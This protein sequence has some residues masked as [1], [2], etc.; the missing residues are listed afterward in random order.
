ML[1]L[2]SKGVVGIKKFVVINATY[3]AEIDETILNNHGDDSIWEHFDDD[4]PLCIVPSTTLEAEHESI[5]FD[6]IS[7]TDGLQI[8][9]GSII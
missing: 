7:V 6:A 9:T 5:V 4:F 8:R 1:I 3:I 2:Y